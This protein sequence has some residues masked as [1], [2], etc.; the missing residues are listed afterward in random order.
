MSTSF[1]M[2]PR[3]TLDFR[4]NW[5]AVLQSGEEVASSEWESDGDAEIG[6]DAHAPTS[7][8]STTTVWVVGGGAVGAESRISNTMTTDS[9]PPRIFKRSFVVRMATR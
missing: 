2:D 8:T 1:E 7:S 4:F 6:A 3:E 9:T 5:A